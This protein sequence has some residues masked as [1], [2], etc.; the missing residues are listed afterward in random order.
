VVE[1]AAEEVEV[2]EEGAEA[3]AK[4]GEAA[5]VVEAAGCVPIGATTAAAA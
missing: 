1:V 2:V 3:A 5:V 4:E